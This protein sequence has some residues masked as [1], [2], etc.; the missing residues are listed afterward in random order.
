Q[1]SRL[2][3]SFGKAVIQATRSSD[4]GIPL[5]PSSFDRKLADAGQQQEFLKIGMPT[6]KSITDA[7][8]AL[9]RFIASPNANTWREAWQL[10]QKEQAAMTDL[11]NN[12]LWQNVVSPVEARTVVYELKLM[13]ARLTALSIRG[14]FI[15]DEFSSADRKKRLEI[16]CADFGFFSAG[17]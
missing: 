1:L 3:Y 4:P 16:E 9:A 8:T 14:G 11:T 13:N 6:A 12:P 10:F 7:R 15:T 17:G 5:S 2:E